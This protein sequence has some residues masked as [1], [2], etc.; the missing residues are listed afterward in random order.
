ML[1]K[2][3]VTTITTILTIAIF[4]IAA[5]PDNSKYFKHTVVKG[6]TVSLLCIQYYG[7]YSPKLGKA[8][9]ALNPSVRDINIIEVGQH[10]KFRKPIAAASKKPSTQKEKEEE[11]FIKQV[12]ATQ[13]VVTYVEGSAYMI[14]KKDKQRKKLSSNQ[15]VYPGDILRTGSD[16]RVEIIINRESVVRMNKNTKMTIEAFRDNKSKSG[17]TKMDFS[18]GSLWAKVRNFKDKISRFELALPTAIA[19]VHGTVYNSTVNPDSSANV[20]VYNGEVSVGSKAP[21]PGAPGEASGLSEVAGPGEVSGPVE[22]S[23][24]QWI[25]IVK[26]M[27]QISIGADGSPGKPK[28]FSKNPRDDWEKWNEERDKRIA[29]MFQKI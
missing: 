6:E 25:E 16:G 26:S 2:Q 12:N 11:V 23:L 15:I 13:G 28:S 7:Y 22:V 8:F 27:Q 24:E 5:T 29:E 1:R 20:K 18:I 4:L 17:K 14:A 19:G 21:S 9:M 3:V 10:L